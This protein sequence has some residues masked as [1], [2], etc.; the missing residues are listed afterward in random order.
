MEALHFSRSCIRTLIFCLLTASITP[1]Y[2]QAE[3]GTAR[4][5]AL[6]GAFTAALLL[7]SNNA[8]ALA[9]KAYFKAKITALR[10]ARCC[11]ISEDFERKCTDMIE[12]TDAD[13]ATRSAKEFS[14]DDYKTLAKDF[15]ELWD[16]TKAGRELFKWVTGTEATK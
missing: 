12:E 6:A 10:A 14:R 16:A 8:H 5:I 4:T 7:C 1:S 11:A 13:C 9:A 15:K 3:H 2:M